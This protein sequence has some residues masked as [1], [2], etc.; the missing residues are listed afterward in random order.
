M[1]ASLLLLTLGLPDGRDGSLAVLGYIHCNGITI[2]WWEPAY[3]A[4][5]AAQR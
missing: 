3:H 1:A 5:A 4:D 2:E